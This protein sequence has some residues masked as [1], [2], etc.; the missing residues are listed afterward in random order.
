MEL[1][2]FDEDVK[3][4]LYKLA[5][6]SLCSTVS[7]QIMTSL[8]V[9]GPEPGDESYE[10][11]EAEKEVIF[12]SLKR[13]AKLVSEG[14]N[15]IDG[16][17]CQPAQGAMYCFPKVEMPKGAI[18]VADELNTTPDSVYAVSLL[19]ATGICVVPASGFAQRPGRYGF[20][21]TFLP[22]ESEMQRCV[23]AIRKHYE[24]FCIDF[25]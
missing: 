1:F 14:L 4:H 5:S 24:A 7:G 17:S 8:M 18:R 3:G 22:S 20:R 9:R 10:S 21:T 15:S 12:Q 2:G 6:A 16:F 19:E 11:H 25:A 23:E 13:R